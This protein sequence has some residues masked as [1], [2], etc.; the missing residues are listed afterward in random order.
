MAFYKDGII[1]IPNVT[2]DVVITATAVQSTEP[3]INLVELYG[4]TAGYRL[5]FG[6]GG[7]SAQ[8]GYCVVGANNDVNG[9]IP[10]KVGDVFRFKGATFPT[11]EDTMLG[12]TRYKNQDGSGYT[13]DGLHLFDGVSNPDFNFSVD[14]DTGVATL[15]ILAMNL[16]QYIR[17]SLKCSDVS[18]LIITKNQEIPV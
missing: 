11:S 15:T 14:H 7:N 1:S 17:F 9:I 12:Y 13:S 18:Q 10:V 4:V 5:S 8:N 3:P 16:K 6:S 2:G